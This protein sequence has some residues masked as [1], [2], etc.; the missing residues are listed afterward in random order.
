MADDDDEVDKILF[1]SSNETI[2]DEFYNRIEAALT[3]GVASLPLMAAPKDDDNDESRDDRMLHKLRKAYIRN[4][5]IM[6]LYSGRNIFSVANR[7]AH[8]R[9][10]IVKSYRSSDNA[11]SNTTVEESNNNGDQTME[12]NETQITGTKEDTVNKF[13][14]KLDIPTKE[15]IPTND[16]MAKLEHEMKALRTKITEAREL[17]KER[18]QY[19]THLEEAASFSG[20]T[21]QALSGLSATKLTSVVETIVE[22]RE[23]FDAIQSQG[24]KLVEKMDEHKKGRALE[25]NENDKILLLERGKKKKPSLEER[26]HEHR[27]ALAQMQPQDLTHVKELLLQQKSA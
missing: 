5:D 1:G 19:F 4:V 2:A 3:E 24:S 18:L 7:T 14:T 16:M 8:F 10:R 6:E 15:D 13:D 27:S 9:Q 26:Y 22:T 23:E 11:S 20:Q 21:K 12:N 17:Q 25:E